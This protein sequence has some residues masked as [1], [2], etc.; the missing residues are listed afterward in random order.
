MSCENTTMYVMNNLQ[1]R[2][3][4]IKML[5]PRMREDK[6]GKH[7]KPQK[8]TANNFYDEMRLRIWEPEADLLPHAGLMTIYRITH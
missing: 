5:H 4:F 3:K 7:A 8:L 2:I 1:Y 6:G